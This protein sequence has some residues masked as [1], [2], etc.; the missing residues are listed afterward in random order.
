[1]EGTMGAGSWLPFSCRKKCFISDD[2][3]FVWR[4]RSGND[5]KK[6]KL[7]E[8][9]KL[10]CDVLNDAAMLLCA[11]LRHSSRQR[12]KQVFTTEH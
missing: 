10:L 5:T 1:M 3:L 9:H 7:L 11:L 2:A 4:L 6:R 8:K 12:M